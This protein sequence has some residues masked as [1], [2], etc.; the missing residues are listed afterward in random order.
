MI[1]FNY[2]KF[3]LPKKGIITPELTLNTWDAN[4][5]RLFTEFNGYF[6]DPSREYLVDGISH[7]TLVDW[8]LVQL[9]VDHD[10]LALDFLGTFSNVLGYAVKMTDKYPVASE[11]FDRYN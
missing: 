2:G 5:K 7:D 9:V 8:W 3:K 4:I 1:R 6:A 10:A 11:G